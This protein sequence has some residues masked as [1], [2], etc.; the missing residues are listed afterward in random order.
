MITAGAGLQRRVVIKVKDRRF[1]ITSGRLVITRK[2][3]VIT[4]RMFVVTTK[5]SLTIA[6]G[7]FE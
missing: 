1:V 6:E 3:L 5:R 4:K 2:R 7:D